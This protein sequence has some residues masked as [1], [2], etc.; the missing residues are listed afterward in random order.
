MPDPIKL[1]P[2]HGLSN[3]AMG[4]AAVCVTPVPLLVSDRGQELVRIEADGRLFHH[5]VEPQ[6]VEGY[7]AALQ[8]MVRV[9]TRS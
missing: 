5:G 9:M 4:F 7:R 8:D 1:A 6:T 3:L 2:V